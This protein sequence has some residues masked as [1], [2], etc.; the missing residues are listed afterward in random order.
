M[1]GGMQLQFHNFGKNGI[2]QF[3]SLL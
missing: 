3:I 1:I 2:F